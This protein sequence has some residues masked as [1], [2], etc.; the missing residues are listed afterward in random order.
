MKNTCAIF[1][2]LVASVGFA[3]S[4]KLEKLKSSNKDWLVSPFEQK[5]TITKEG[6][7]IILNN[8]C[9][10]ASLDF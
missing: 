9:H 8:G 3:Q 5:A 1:L 7:N 10:L 2:I 4:D 6:Q